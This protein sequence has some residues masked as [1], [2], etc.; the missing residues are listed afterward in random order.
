MSGSGL[1]RTALLVRL[2]WL[3]GLSDLY[4]SCNHAFVVSMSDREGR[5]VKEHHIDACFIVRD[6]WSVRLPPKVGRNRPCA[7]VASYSAL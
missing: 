1:N 4:Q 3:A 7:Y 5:L 2:H 6:R